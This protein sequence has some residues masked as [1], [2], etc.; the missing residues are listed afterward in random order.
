MHGLLVSLLNFKMAM[1]LGEK[2]GVVLSTKHS[3]EIIG[4]D[5]I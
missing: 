3:N 2:I 1:E 5:F 4:G